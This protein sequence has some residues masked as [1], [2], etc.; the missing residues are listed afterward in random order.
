MSPSSAYAHSYVQTSCSHIPKRLLFPYIF[1]WVCHISFVE[2]TWG[3]RPTHIR[4]RTY[5]AHMCMDVDI[6]HAHIHTRT[7]IQSTYVHGCW[8]L[9]CLQAWSLRSILSDMCAVL[10]LCLICVPCWFC[11]WYVCRVDFV[12]SDMPTGLDPKKHFACVTGKGS[13]MDNPSEYLKSFYMFDYIGY[14]L[15]TFFFNLTT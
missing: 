11:V 6:R 5:K 8:Y 2:V 13:P 10:I 3:H 9:N 15:M 12:I 7:Y 1:D 4:A 14:A